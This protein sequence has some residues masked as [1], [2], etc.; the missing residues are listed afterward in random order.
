MIYLNSLLRTSILFSAEAMYNVKEM[1][2]RHI[3]RIEKDIIR[4][5]F[6]NGKGCA[7]YQLYL[8]T[9]Q[10]PARIVIKKMKL[11]FV[12]YILSQKEDL[13]MFRF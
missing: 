13:L 6:K 4:K 1:E 8:E 3:E 12:H 5:I 11:I 7:G 2:Y 9:G 10:L